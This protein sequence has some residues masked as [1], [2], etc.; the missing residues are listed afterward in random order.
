MEDLQTSNGMCCAVLQI[1]KAKPNTMFNLNKSIYSIFKSDKTHTEIVL[2]SHCIKFFFHLV[3][4]YDINE[5]RMTKSCRIKC[6]RI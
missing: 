4:S 1:Y 3:V 5:N 6:L 2:N